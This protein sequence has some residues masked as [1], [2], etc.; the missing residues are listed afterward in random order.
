MLSISG[1]VNERV[2]TFDYAR[3]DIHTHEWPSTK[4][5]TNDE[6]R[7][8]S[9]QVTD[10]FVRYLQEKDAARG[11]YD[12]PTSGCA[13]FCDKSFLRDYQNKKAC[14]TS[15]VMLLFGENFGVH[16]PEIV[17]VDECQRLRAHDA[18]MFQYNNTHWKRCVLDDF[19]DDGGLC[20]DDKSCQ[21]LTDING[22][23]LPD[24]QQRPFCKSEYEVSCPRQGNMYLEHDEDRPQDAANKCEISNENPAGFLCKPG[25][26]CLNNTCTRNPQTIGRVVTLND[27]Y[28]EDD[29]V[30]ECEECYESCVTDDDCPAEAVCG[31]YQNADTNCPEKDAPQKEEPKV[32]L[33][34]A[35]S[36]Q[37]VVVELPP[38]IG[39][40]TYEL[41]TMGFY[42]RGR[43]R[44]RVGADEEAVFMAPVAGAN[45]K[46]DPANDLF[47]MTFEECICMG[48]STTSRECANVDNLLA[49]AL[50]PDLTDKLSERS[51]LG[52]C[53]DDS[54]GKMPLVY[55]KVEG[56]CKCM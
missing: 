19:H 9:P 53:G 46:L 34:S 31:V 25:T 56:N 27:G 28:K 3:P 54:A 37:H 26:T 40:T 10:G 8:R 42:P 39:P 12:T 15:A 49:P 20:D 14:E 43:A 22:N 55:Q 23:V 50:H 36:D 16:K 47:V 2:W 29:I 17:F 5:N 7:W 44:R 1:V 51:E 6:D 48:M 52:A 35:H 21:V 41:R 30:P 32:C 38:S 4:L 11:N 45:G 24:S 13:K 18:R 33:R